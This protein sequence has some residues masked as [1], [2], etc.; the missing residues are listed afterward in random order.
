MAN[1][2]RLGQYILLTRE[3]WYSVEI[4]LSAVNW[5]TK[6]SVYKKFT[7]VNGY[8]IAISSWQFQSKMVERFV[9]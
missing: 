6:E 3:T 5:L 7:T 2:N 8:Q 4:N 9:K 1:D